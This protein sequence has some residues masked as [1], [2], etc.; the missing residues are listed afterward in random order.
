MP[1]YTNKQGIKYF[2]EDEITIEFARELHAHSYQQL[3]RLKRLIIY[4]IEDMENR[5]DYL[6]SGIETEWSLEWERRRIEDKK[7]DN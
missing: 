4:M 2:K 6:S 1:T 5:E 7:I 3:K